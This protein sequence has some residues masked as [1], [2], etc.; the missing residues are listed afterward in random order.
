M[1]GGQSS[2]RESPPARLRCCRIYRPSISPQQA[3]ESNRL[4]TPR[5]KPRNCGSHANWVTTSARNIGGPRNWRGRRSNRIRNRN[6]SQRP[7][8]A[9][10]EFTEQD[11][12]EIFVS[13]AFLAFKNSHRFCLERPAAFPAFL[14][15]TLK[16]R[17][18]N[19]NSSQRPRSA[20]TEFTEQDKAGIFVSL[21]FFVFN[22]SVP[23]GLDFGRADGRSSAS[24]NAEHCPYLRSPSIKSNSQGTLV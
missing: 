20:D 16:I 11:K 8:S 1:R 4:L 17:I 7:R 21:A 22:T 24:V 14:S 3:D 5:I 23:Y 9:D 15:P 10:T 2:Q 12:A 6:S 19:R 13:L 18:R